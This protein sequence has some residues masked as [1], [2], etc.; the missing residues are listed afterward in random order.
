M[1]SKDFPSIAELA[2][3]K[4]END[5]YRLYSAEETD[6]NNPDDRIRWRLKEFF[7]DD[8]KKAKILDRLDHSVL[9]S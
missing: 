7:E 6:F 9:E 8:P 2:R 3:V 4:A 1:I 5:N